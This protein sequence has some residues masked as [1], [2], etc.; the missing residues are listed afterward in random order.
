MY[1]VRFGIGIFNKKSSYKEY[2]LDMDTGIMG[3][4]W[5]RPDNFVDQIDPQ[6]NGKFSFLYC[7][8]VVNLQTVYRK[9]MSYLRFGA[10]I[11]TQPNSSI[12]NLQRVKDMAL[13]YLELQGIS[14]NG[15]RLNISATV[16]ALRGNIGSGVC[17][18]YSSLGYS[19]VAKHAYDVLLGELEKHYLKFKNLKRYNS[20]PLNLTMCYERDKEEEFKN[21]PIITFHFKGTQ[22][23]MVVIP[24][25]SFEVVDRYNS[26]R[27]RVLWFGN[28]IRAHQQTN[29]RSIYDTKRKQLLFYLEN[30]L[31]NA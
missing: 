8:P 23:N 6:S 31:K 4:G 13:Y 25:G 1:I 24:E 28:V 12:T 5:G 19:R 10:D 14:L 17:I 26:N 21:L 11:P 2:Y 30:C 9:T 18:I 16:F 3:M 27:K 15:R 29:Q 7:L 20:N 22:A